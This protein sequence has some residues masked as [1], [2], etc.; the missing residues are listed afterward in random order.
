MLRRKIDHAAWRWP[1]L[2]S[3]AALAFA[4]CKNNGEGASGRPDEPAASPTVGHLQSS[5][6]DAQIANAVANQIALDPMNDPGRIDVTSTDGIIH[7]TGQASNLRAH[8]RAEKI[9]ETVRGVRAV[10]NRLEVET[11]ER[12]DGTIAS[13]VQNALLMNPATD[14]YEVDVKVTDGHVVLRGDVDSWSEKNLASQVVRG[15][16][17]VRSVDNQLTPVYAV[18]RR[19]AEIEYDIEQRIHWDVLVDDALL[20]VEVK[21]GVA[22]LHGVVG[23]A[24]ERSQAIVDAWVSG[25]RQ[26]DPDGLEV[27]WWLARDELRANKYVAKTPAEIKE[28]LQD[29]LLFDPRVNDYELRVAVSGGVA[30]LTGT[31]DTL[32][33]KFAAQHVAENTVGVNRVINGIMLREA[34]ELTDADITDQV[35]VGLLIDVIADSVEVD[36]S[37]T[38]G[39]VTLT[40]TVDNRFEKSQAEGVVASVPG[41][42]AVHNQLEI[43]DDVVVYLTSP[44]LYDVDRYLVTYLPKRSLLED[45]KLLDEVKDELFWSP[46]VDADDI[47]IAVKDGVVTLTGDVLTFR[48]KQAARNEALE[49]GAIAVHDEVRVERLPEANTK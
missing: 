36:V 37:T 33:S 34:G 4:G 22:K 6:T 17:G 49:A 38:N 18:E 25:V 13:A 8:R 23:S 30:T 39:V 10:V 27:K 45:I 40:G 41:V 32:E 20:V 11:P 12:P 1:M 48:A 16:R 2:L 26:V 42:R 35:K 7:L 44:F 28:A 3:L 47:D 29:A 46:Y 9:A 14:A 43:A 24:A 15:V 31:V 19:D 5:L 21:D